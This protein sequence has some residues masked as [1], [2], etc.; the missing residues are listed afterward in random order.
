MGVAGVVWVV[1]IQR[2][3]AV[4]LSPTSLAP[5][6]LPPLRS[7]FVWYPRLSPLYSLKASPMPDVATAA[8]TLISFNPATGEPV[9][10]VPVTPLDQLPLIVKNARD[11]QRGWGAL[12]FDQRAAILIDAGKELEA[13]AERIGTMITHEMGKPLASGIGESKYVAT[14]FAE[15]LE[16][17][18]ASIQSECLE[19]DDTITTMRYDAFGVVAAITPWNFPLLMPHQ[20][21]LPAL[22]AGN[23]VIL[24]PS[25][26][27][28]LVA[29]EYVAVLNRVLP[30]NVLQ[31]VHG[32]ELQGKALV[33][34]P[35][36]LVVFTGSREA[37][38]HI[39]AEASRGLKRVILELGG[40][41]PLIVLK[42]A[43]IDAAATFA[44]NNSFRNAGQVCVSTERIYVDQSIADE[45]NAALVAKGRAFVQGA[46]TDEGVTVGP[47]INARQ[48]QHVQSQ[49]AAA[50]HD[51]A[52]MLLGSEEAEGNFH[53]LTVLDGVTHDM[54]IMTEETF[55]PVACVMRVSGDTEAVKMANDTRF[56]LAAAVFGESLHAEEVAGQLTAGMIGVN[57]GCGGA[58]GSPW[59]GAKESGYGW[60]SGPTGHRQFC[61]IRT[62]SRAKKKSD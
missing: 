61:Q 4:S 46:G 57:K 11:A 48:K 24:K 47:M 53:P 44:A 6:I 1:S 15:E 38:K 49:V 21:V 55:G 20:S 56:G 13:D 50:V 7:R 39:L 12:T 3:G 34:S 54:L 18:G 37:G 29:H 17:I 58:K 31:I 8:A 40:K 2:F 43:D 27:T 5:W 36:D 23:T 51:G 35:V 22:A 10:E 19:D 16:E 62:L 14:S 26:E 52:T 42:G 45:F 60:H 33:E 41:D 28:P 9:G 30:P 59:V 25:E 32:N